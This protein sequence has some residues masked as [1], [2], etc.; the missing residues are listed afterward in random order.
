MSGGESLHTNVFA[1]YIHHWAYSYS[2]FRCEGY[3]IYVL[4]SAI[5]CLTA[6]WSSYHRWR[7][8]EVIHISVT[9]C[10]CAVP[11]VAATYILSF[12][13]HSSLTCVARYDD[14][15]DIK[16]CPCL[17]RQRCILMNE[18]CQLISIDNA[19][20][21]IVQIVPCAWCEIVHS[22]MEQWKGSTPH[23]HNNVSIIEE[24]S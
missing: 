23:S 4:G 11:S 10:V 14:V 9:V 15:D 5:E 19:W 22:L 7:Q 16:Q 1:L 24:L 20:V 8:S 17:S 21:Y 2:S 18:L 12:A 3:Y 6:Y 13:S